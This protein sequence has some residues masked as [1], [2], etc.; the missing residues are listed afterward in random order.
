VALVLVKMS[1]EDQ[2]E[3]VSVWLRDRNVIIRVGAREALVRSLPVH[4][5]SADALVEQGAVAVDVDERMFDGETVEAVEV[6]GHGSGLDEGGFDGGIFPRGCLLTSPGQGVV[7]H[8]EGDEFVLHEAA[9]AD[10]VVEQVDV[11]GGH[12]NLLIVNCEL[13]IVNG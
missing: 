8:E 9:G 10:G 3:I 11:Q 1:E 5:R 6:G 12:G 13:R 2:I 4:S 7:G